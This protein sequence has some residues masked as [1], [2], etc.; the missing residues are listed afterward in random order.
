MQTKCDYC[1]KKV[2]KSPKN[3]SKYKH[4][5]CNHECYSKYKILNKEE[6]ACS[7]SGIHWHKILNDAKK[8]KLL[9]QPKTLNTFD[10]FKKIKEG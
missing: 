1:L 2:T 5:F 7:R 3:I 8:Q 10:G 6:F 9:P 4:H